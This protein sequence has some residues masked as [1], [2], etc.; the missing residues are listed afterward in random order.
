MERCSR[1]KNPSFS[2]SLLD[3]IYRSMDDEHGDTSHRRAP[4]RSSNHKKQAEQPMAAPSNDHCHYRPSDTDYRRRSFTPSSSSSSSSSSTTTTAAATGSS[5]AGFSSSS[6]VESIRSDR[7]PQPDLLDPGKKKKKSKCGSI[8]TGLRSLRK[9]REPASATA[10]GSSPASPGARLASFLNALFASAGS[11]KKPKIPIPA[12]ATV[13]AAAGGGGE[14]SACSF[15]TSSCRRSCLSKTPAAADRR[16][17]SGADAG[18]RSVRF[19]PVSVIVDEDSQPCGHKR[20]Q[21]DA[22]NTATPMAARVEELLR[23]AGA[24]AE[25]EA[26][27]EGDGAGSDSSS[28]LFELENLTVMMRGGRFRNELP[29][30]ETTNPNTNRA[31]AQGLI[32]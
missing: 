30:Y 2:S 8:R 28:D 22:G 23:V 19:Y 4:D 13:A 26:E 15:S 5:S 17:A 29:V 3:A 20:L 18:K 27:E 14:D 31:I 7:I 25:V 6:D 24:G 21:D 9:S 32:H 10:A 1:S 11:P 16:R 12:A